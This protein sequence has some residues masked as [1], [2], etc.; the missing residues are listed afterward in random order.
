MK[1]ILL[2]LIVIFLVAVGMIVSC[3]KSENSS[4][5]T[6]TTCNQTPEAVAANDASSK[7]IYKGVLIGSSGTIKFDVQNSSSSTLIAT[8]VI[9]GTTVQLTGQI[10]PTTGTYTAVYSGT[11]NNQPCSVTF[12]VYGDGTSPSI[13]ASNIPGHTSAV[14][15]VIKETSS[16]LARCF[17]GT[18]HDASD[19]SDGTFNIVVST[20]LKGWAGKSRKNGSTT[21]NDVSGVYA[22]NTLYWGQTTT[23]ATINGDT[24]DGT[25]NNGSGN[26][27]VKGKR[28][29]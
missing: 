15:I 6:C 3:K 14:F 16:V 27:T 13:T 29:L 10:A 28:T 24:F 4:S 7:G 23:I 20:I 1:K 26:I 25:F 19:N 2:S 8:L 11:Y 5:Y 17:E 18:Y 22:N 12:S 21:T 9:D